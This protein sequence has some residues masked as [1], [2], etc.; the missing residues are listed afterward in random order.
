MYETNLTLPGS[1]C[2]PNM[3][4]WSKHIQLMTASAVHVM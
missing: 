4:Q 2:N 1:E 3:L